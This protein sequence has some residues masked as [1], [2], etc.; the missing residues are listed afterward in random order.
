MS[1]YFFSLHPIA[2]SLTIY[3]SYYV[4]G[5]MRSTISRTETGLSPLKLTV[6]WNRHLKR[7]SPIRLFHCWDNSQHT[8]IRRGLICSRFQSMTSWLQG[9]DITGKRCDR[10]KLLRSLWLGSRPGEECES[11]SRWVSD[12]DSKASPPWPTQTNEA[13]APTIPRCCLKANQIKTPL[14]PQ[15]GWGCNWFVQYML[16]SLRPS[17]QS[18]EPQKVQIKLKIS[19]TQINHNW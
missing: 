19:T 4:P 8:Q 17:V 15:E 13:C 14:Y 3:E 1:Q 2:H 18:P 7:K 11:P 10:A 16:A 5:T 12:I 6:R 9:R